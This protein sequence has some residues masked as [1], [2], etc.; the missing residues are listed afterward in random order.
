M[1]GFS[2]IK[3]RIISVKVNF[4]KG[5]ARG[6]IRQITSVVLARAD[7]F[8]IPLLRKVETIIKF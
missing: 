8:K 4:P 5:K 7:W 3:E 2:K 1:E 6:F